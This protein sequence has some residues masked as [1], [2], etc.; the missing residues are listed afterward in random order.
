MC[1]AI[2]VLA[3]KLQVV[4]FDGPAALHRA[5]DTRHRSLGSV[6]RGDQ[7]GIVG[8]DAIQCGSK[9]VGIALAA[10]FAVGHDVDAGALHVS[11]GHD[12][13]VVLRFLE[14]FGRQPPHR[15]HAGARH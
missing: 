7:R 2:G 4:Q 15:M 6:P 8:V 5:Y 3:Q 13:G 11:D 9:A 12:G 10:D 1:G 14:M